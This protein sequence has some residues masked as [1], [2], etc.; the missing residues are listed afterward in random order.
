MLNQWDSRTRSGSTKTSHSSIGSATSTLW[1]TASAMLFLSSFV[2]Q[3]TTWSGN[4]TAR[5]TPSDWLSHFGWP[6]ASRSPSVSLF[7][8][9]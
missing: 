8:Y 5:E 4:E 7:V 3:W 1:T 2:M 9:W 6:T